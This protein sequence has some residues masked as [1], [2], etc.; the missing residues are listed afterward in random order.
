MT[1]NIITSNAAETKA[2]GKKLGAL[3]KAGDCVL[4]AGELGA[5]KTT[6]T[7]GL[8]SALKI[9]G[10]VTSPT[11]VIAREHKSLTDGPNLVHV[12]AYRL[13]TLAEISQLDLVTDIETAILVVEWGKGLVNDLVAEPIQITID[14]ND[15]D[16]NK[17]EFTINATTAI[18]EGLS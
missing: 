2:L 1:L 12:D 8:A 4:L 18:L 5:G 13:S 15:E 11:F 3:L 9:K 16:E 10:D 17:R 6:F 7:Q 14:H